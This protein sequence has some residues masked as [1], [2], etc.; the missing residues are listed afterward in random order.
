MALN[1]KLKSKLRS[2]ARRLWLWY[3]DERKAVIKAAKAKNNKYTCQSCNNEFK[4]KEIHV[5]HI[6]PCGGFTTIKE[7]GTWLNKLFCPEDN[8]RILCKNC[9]SIKTQADKKIS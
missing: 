3:S 2:S 4:L 5:D 1:P 7:F 6:I 9:H 8:L